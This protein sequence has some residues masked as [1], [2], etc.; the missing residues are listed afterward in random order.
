MSTAEGRPQLDR[1]NLSR[2]GGLESEPGI[3]CSRLVRQCLRDIWAFEPCVQ[4]QL[5]LLRPEVQ[6]LDWCA[7]TD[8]PSTNDQDVPAP[9]RMI[10][11]TE[12]RRFSER[13][14]SKPTGHQ[15]GEEPT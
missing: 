5:V 8:D 15:T 3:R 7:T 2:K 11:V 14:T 9:V 12:E 6:A 4:E 1:T 13:A 10:E